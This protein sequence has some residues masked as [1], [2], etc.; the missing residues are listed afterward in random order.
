MKKLL[1]I[2]TIIMLV[3]IPLSAQFTSLPIRLVTSSGTPLTGEAGNIEFTKYP[4][5]YPADKISGI[6]VNEIGT[7]GNYVAKGFSEFRYVKLWLGGIEQTWFDSV[8]TGNI[9]SYLN[10]NYVTLGT[11]QTITGSK[12]TTGNWSASS[13]GNWLYSG[14][15]TT[16]TFYRPYIINSSPWYSDLSQIPGTGMLFRSA[17][18]S[19]YLKREFVYY[20]ESENRLYF[21]TPGT[22]GTFRI[23]KRGNGQLFEMN[24]AQFTWSP[25]TGLNL[26]SAVLNQDSIAAKIFTGLKD[27]TWF[28]LGEPLSKYRTL[29]LRKP[30]WN[31]PL[32]YP[33][34]KWYYTSVS[35][36][37]VISAK[38]SF[39]VMNHADMTYDETPFEIF[40]DAL[41]NDCDTITLPIR[42]LY[43]I[44]YNCN[45]IFPYT[46]VAGIF[47]RDSITMRMVN[48]LSVDIPASYL[49]EFREFYDGTR[50]YPESHVKSRTFTL[51]NPLPGTKYYLQVKGVLN[52]GLINIAVTKP[53]ITYMLV[54]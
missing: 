30:F 7:A 37:G 46:E 9:F 3:Q 36:T 38:D 33:D 41:W 28:S 22:L 10:S 11:T 4:H 47:A 49:E 8:L 17:G 23:A 5:N 50:Y 34:W 14:S 27:S 13:T 39:T 20:S 18:D 21:N 43:H 16:N 42:G 24:P 51:F 1:L 48:E 54:R 12:N 15:G 53:Q 25:V 40:A 45:V 52:S 6:T 35:E 29:S 32:P 26:N 2:L 31:N 19:L 44:T